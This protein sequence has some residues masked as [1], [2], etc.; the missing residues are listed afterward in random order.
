MT[1]Y[2][3]WWQSFCQESRSHQSPK[4]AIIDWD[5]GLVAEGVGGSSA[6][7][8]PVEQQEVTMGGGEDT[9]DNSSSKETYSQPLAQRSLSL[10]LSLS[11]FVC[12]TWSP[13]L[14]VSL[15][16]SL[17]PPFLSLSP[18]CF[19]LGLF[20]LSFVNL[21]RIA[22]LQLCQKGVT[23]NLFS[24]WVLIKP[25][26]D[27]VY[28]IDTNMNTIISTWRRWLACFLRRQKKKKITVDIFLDAVEVRFFK[29]CLIICFINLYMLVLVSMV[30]DYFQDHREFEKEKVYFLL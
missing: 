27:S 14:S 23:E 5:H 11:G 4:D 7:G 2:W 25:S 8:P 10:S 17:S 16:L 18:V 29:P 30:S 22:R 13:T 24:W 19:F 26:S 3:S 9:A 20:H 6:A 28:M 15:F 1:G 21:Y 12:L